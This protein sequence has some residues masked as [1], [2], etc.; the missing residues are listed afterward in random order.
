MQLQGQK[1]EKDQAAGN[2]AVSTPA[3]W[4]ECAWRSKERKTG[5]GALNASNTP[6]P[7]FVSL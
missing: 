2:N 4:T 7:P 3:P 1:E 5:R 6:T